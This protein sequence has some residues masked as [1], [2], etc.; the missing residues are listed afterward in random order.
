[1]KKTVCLI[2]TCCM[3]FLLMSC[4]LQEEPGD[5]NRIRLYYISNSGIKLEMHE[6]ALQTVWTDLQIREVIN[7]L[8]TMPEK[9]EY[10]PPFTMG[11]TVLDYSL[12]EG[13]LTL[14]LGENYRSLSSIEEVLVRAALVRSFTQLEGIDYVAITV[15]G[16][17]LHDSLGNV[18][19]LMSAD[20]FIDKV[21]DEISTYEKARLKLYFANEAGDALLAVNR[22]LAYNSNIPLER[23]VIE[24]ILSGPGPEIPE[25]HPTVNPDTKLVGVTV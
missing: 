1:M 13:R 10:K 14:D 9:L 5:E 16:E 3:A 25:A 20:Q 15:S 17:P 18:V 19:G 6:Y 24:Q 2:L 11:F 8:S 7:Q 23:L 21:D 22:T 12:E 4:G